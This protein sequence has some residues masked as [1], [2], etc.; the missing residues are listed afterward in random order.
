MTGDGVNDAPAL[1]RADIGIAMGITGTDV[2]KQ[3]ADMVLTDDNFASIVSAV[4]QGRII[5]SNI[6]KFVFFLLSCNLGE[7]GTIFLGTLFGWPLPLTAIQLLWMNLVTDGAPALA[8]GLEKGEPG[9]MGRPPR[10]TGEPIIN[11]SMILALAMQTVAITAVTLLAF[12]IGR[13]V[14]GGVVEARTMAFVVLSGCQLVRA[15]T[16][17]SERASIFS[18]GVFSNRSMQYAVGLSTLLLLAVVYIPYV[19]VVF[20]AAPLSLTQWAYMAPLLFVPAIVD[21]LTKLGL[22]IAERRAER[23]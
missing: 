8:L 14:F 4:E 20:N 16:N 18:I 12:W 1:K 3:T 13:T 10:P 9:I 23:R 11:R 17:R 7:I 5:F 6:R 2:T 22:R 15:Y 19:N 21:E